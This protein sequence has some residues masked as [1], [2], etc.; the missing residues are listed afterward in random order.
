MRSALFL[1]LGVAIGVGVQ[2]A[3]GQ[4]REVVS[5]NHVAIA[6]SDFAAASRFYSEGMGFPEGIGF[7]SML[8]SGLRFAAPEGNR[9]R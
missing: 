1:V 5:L 3:S 8:E 2:T 9:L 4:Q 6:V 7:P